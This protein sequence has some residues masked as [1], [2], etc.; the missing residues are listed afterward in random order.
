[1]K[2]QATTGSLLTY[3]PNPK[4]KEP[5]QPGR[6]G[7]LCP[8][9]VAIERAEGLLRESFLYKRQRFAVDRGRVFV[10]KAD[11]CGGWH[12]YPAGWREM[13]ETVRQHFLQS[14]AV[15][16]RDLSRYWERSDDEQ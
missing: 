9:D 1:M 8:K 4:H 7:S 15:Q 2:A 16:H 10:G 6:K 5:W 14:G 11:N 12:G 3:H 13:P